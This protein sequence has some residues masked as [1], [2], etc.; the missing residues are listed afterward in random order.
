MSVRLRRPSLLGASFVLIAAC[1]NI[2]GFEEFESAPAGVGGTT[3]RAGSV[4][5]GGDAAAG[6]GA[7]G[8]NSA[9]RGGTKASGGSGGSQASGGDA[10]GGGAADDAGLAVGEACGAE[11]ECARGLTCLYGF[12]RPECSDETD[13]AQGSVCL[14][15]TA[16]GG[17][18]RLASETCDPDCENGDLVCALDGTCRIACSE[19][20]SC[21]SPTQRCIAGT[22]VSTVGEDASAWDCGET[23]DG[24]LTCDGRRL[25]VCNVAGPGLV[26]VDTCPST[27]LCEASLPAEPTYDADEPPACVPGCTAGK[28]YCDGR[29]L[30][31]CNDDG[32]GPVDV[33]TD[34]PTVGLCEASV[35]AE[36]A[37]CLSAACDAGEARCSGGETE[38]TLQTCKPDR[39]AFADAS[40]CGDA[41]AQC[42]PG[43]SACFALDIDATEVSAGD[44]DAWLQTAPPTTGQAHGCEANGSFAPDATCLLDASGPCTGASCDAPVVCV[45]WCDAAAYCEARGRRLCGRIG[46]GMTPFERAD[47]PG[48]SQWMNACS[49]GGQFAWG[50]GGAPQAGAERC[51]YFGTSNGATY[52]VGTHDDCHSPSPGYAAIKDLSGNVEE[53]EDACEAVVTAPA[54][55]AND[56]CRTRGGSVRSQTTA[57]LRCDAL[58]ASAATRGTHSP[59][60]GFRCCGS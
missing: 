27:A 31:L 57:E 45:D 54:A 52:A 28:P 36:S 22:C 33:G 20:D 39:T 41:A 32:A 55:G 2:L 10:G 7:T 56:A 60:L 47:D 9:G 53:W 38:L 18:C 30:L 4:G 59:S 43:A 15:R 14:F 8:G 1:Q 34:C 24:E 48:V 42:N 21:D 26:A 51:W 58:P 25:A 49:A 23:P 6:D 29:T 35:D 37:T 17:G 13:C 11:G 12:C 40:V 44:Y 50:S 16:T 46:G 3:G 5:T 19:K